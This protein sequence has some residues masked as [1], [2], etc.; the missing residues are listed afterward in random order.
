MYKYQILNKIQPQ[1]SM[2]LRRLLATQKHYKLLACV[3]DVYLYLVK[4]N[5]HQNVS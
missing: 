2:R 3:A 4:K 5:K 1:H